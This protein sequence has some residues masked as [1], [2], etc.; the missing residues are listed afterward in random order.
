MNICARPS[1]PE[2]V[3]VVIV[4]DCTLALGRLYLR[5]LL[6][7]SHRCEYRFVIASLAPTSITTQEPFIIESDL[8][9]LIATVLRCVTDAHAM[10]A[11]KFVVWRA[12]DAPTHALLDAALTHAGFERLTSKHAREMEFADG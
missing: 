6:G 5:N 7:P 9:D 1:L 2:S 8:D 10:Y 4:F 3:A 11:D 12:L